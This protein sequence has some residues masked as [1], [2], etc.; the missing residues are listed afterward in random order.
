M[1]PLH[2]DALWSHDR[3]VCFPAT[4]GHRVVRT[5]ISDVSSVPGR[6]HHLWSNIRGTTGTT[7]DCLRVTQ[8][9]ELEAEAF[10]MLLMPTKFRVFGTCRFS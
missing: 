9:R 5:V 3:T 4:Y 6:H 2:G 8:G 1:L 7:R 10:E